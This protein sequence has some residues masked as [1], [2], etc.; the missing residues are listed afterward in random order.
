MPGRGAI[1]LK[2]SQHVAGENRWW[3]CSTKR[4]RWSVAGANAVLPLRAA[5][6]NDRYDG[7]WQPPGEAPPVAA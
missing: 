3:S 5:V 2:S 1:L 7:F 4:T 6:L